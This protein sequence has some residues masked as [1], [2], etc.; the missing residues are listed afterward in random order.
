MHLISDLPSADELRPYL[1]RIDVNRWYTNFGP[2]ACE[3]E[4]KLTALLAAVDPSPQHGSV[5]VTTIATCYHALEVGLRITG[6]TPGGKVLIPAVSFAACPLAARHAGGEVIFAD[7]DPASWVLTPAI[8]RRVVAKVKLDAVMPLTL[9]GIP[10]PTEEWDAFSRETGIP[11]IIDAAAAIESQSI[12]HKGF[13]AHSLHAT[14]PF[15]VGEGGLLVAR[16][17]DIVDKARL[18]SNFGTAERIAI[19]DGTNSK[20][21]EYHAAV[22]LAQAM[23]WDTNKKKR[24][25]LLDVYRQHLTQL[26]GRVSLHPSIGKAVVSLL[27]LRFEAPIAD[28]VIA[29]AKKEGLAMHRT[30]LPPLYQHPYYAGVTLASA[31]GELLHGDAPAAKKAAHMKHSEAMYRHIA[32]VPFHSFMGEKEVVRVVETMARLSAT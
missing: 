4:Q 27:M 21:S 12:L 31:D 30:Y 32:G 2:L 3:L 20:M 22:G 11:V 15:G 7:V 14:K 8:A 28:R 16:D 19:A 5:H 18:Y 6:V 10:L 25:A 29:A 1:R 26:A 23:R 13:V 17:A 9:Y 24:R